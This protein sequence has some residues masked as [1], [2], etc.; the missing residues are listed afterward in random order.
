MSM[1]VHLN[2]FSGTEPDALAEISA[3]G[4]YPLASDVAPEHN[5]PHFHPFDSIVFI[6]DG[7]LRFHDVV[8][9]EFHVCPPGTRIDDLGDNL[10]R[11]DHDGYRAIVGFAQDPAVLF[12]GALKK[13][14]AE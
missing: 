12:A 11:E 10:H 9:G 14:T 8:T 1:I 3:M 4:W 5:E 13:E 2:A 7:V 6:V